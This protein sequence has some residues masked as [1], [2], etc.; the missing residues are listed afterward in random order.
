MTIDRNLTAIKRK[1][2]SVTGALTVVAF[3]VPMMSSTAMAQTD[4]QE[5]DAGL[6]SPIQGSWI[7]SIDRYNQGTTFTAVASFAAGGVFLATGSGDRIDPISPLYGTWKHTGRNRY[8]STTY[9]FAFDPAGHPVAMIKTNQV[10]HF[11]SRNTL[12]GSGVG[13]A[14]NLQG[15]NCVSVPAVSIHIKA[16]RVIVEKV[17]EDSSGTVSNQ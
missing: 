17:D 4:L 13:F 9:F 11:K 3:A 1:A 6:W 5:D 16:R 10:F 8:D 7:F 12:V 15:Q 2:L 14:C